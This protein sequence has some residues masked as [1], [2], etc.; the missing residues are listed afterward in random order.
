M[1]IFRRLTSEGAIVR[2]SILAALSLA[3][4]LVT[5]A[6][7]AS[8]ATINFNIVVNTAPL[9]AIPGRARFISTSS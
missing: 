8:A 7:P 5:T 1:V 3:L 4:A 2:K 6:V 9:V